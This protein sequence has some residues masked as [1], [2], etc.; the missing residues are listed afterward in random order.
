[1]VKNLGGNKCKKQ[2]RKKVTVPQERKLRYRNKSESE[3]KYAIVT[4]IYG[5]A[6]CSVI[7][8]DN[9][10]R[11]CI[12]RNK[13]RGR[14]KRDNTIS[15]NSWILVGVREWEARG[16]K[17]QKCDLLEVYN[18]SEKDKLISNV[19]DE[20]MV[21]INNDEQKNVSQTI[22]GIEFTEDNDDVNISMSDTENNI[23]S[24]EENVIDIDEI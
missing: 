6:N 21:L 18:D 12:I 7:C 23:L 13:F 16:D 3:E 22:E 11:H 8:M 2:A 15:V 19:K 20:V 10:T 14:D 17:P 24:E 1:M 4:K 5:G 9:V